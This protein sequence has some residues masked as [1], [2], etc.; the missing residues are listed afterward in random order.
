[1]QN[2]IPQPV[3]QEEQK[4]KLLRHSHKHQSENI[5]TTAPHP[6]PRRGRK[7]TVP[8]EQREQLRRVSIDVC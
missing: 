3:K 7:S 8:P 4:Q 6:T 5:A 1:M 2:T